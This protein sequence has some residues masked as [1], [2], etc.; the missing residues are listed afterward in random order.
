M[1][2]SLADLYPLQTKGQNKSIA[3]ITLNALSGLEEGTFLG[4]APEI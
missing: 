3:D 2:R 1:L 4:W